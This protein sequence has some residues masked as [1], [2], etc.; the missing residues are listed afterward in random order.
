MRT[1]GEA[2]KRGEWIHYTNT[3]NGNLCWER[4][5]TWLGKDNGLWC[6]MLFGTSEVLG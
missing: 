4:R 1:I 2:V 5:K 3:E 6:C